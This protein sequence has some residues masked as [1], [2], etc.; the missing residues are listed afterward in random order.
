MALPNLSGSNIQD[1][2]QRV[3]HTDGDVVYDGTGSALPISLH[4]HITFNLT[5]EYDDGN[6]SVSS[7][8]ANLS[9]VSLPTQNIITIHSQS[10]NGINLLP[11][12]N[13]YFKDIGSQITLT[14]TTSPK[15]WIRAQVLSYNDSV[16]G[17]QKYHFLSATAITGSAGPPEAGD[18]VEFKWD[19]SAGVGSIKHPGGWLDDTSTRIDVQITSQS[20]YAPALGISADAEVSFTDT[21]HIAASISKSTDL[22]V[23]SLN[24]TTDITASGDIS[25]SGD[26]IASNVSASGNFV[27]A[28]N[29][30]LQSENQDTTYIKLV[31]DDYWQVYANGLETAKFASTQVVINETGQ[32]QVD[33]R[34]ESNNESHLLFTDAGA[35]KVTIGTDTPSDSL[36]TVARDVTVQS[37]ITASGNISSSGTI[38]A[39]SFVGNMDGG[40]F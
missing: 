4:P 32:S 9:T 26:V 35:E 31:N 33:F 10:L 1:T 29:S 16:D 8:F 37:H 20:I 22:T 17:V 21:L 18:V 13:S 30:R 3:L 27:L 7:S 38:T 36:F 5:K 25:A 2:F 12:S 14:T 24:T 11:S 39:T 34:V 19:N 28:N 15:K 6:L 23:N 40:T